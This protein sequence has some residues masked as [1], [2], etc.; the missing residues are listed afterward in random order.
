MLTCSTVDF[1]IENGVN[2]LVEVSLYIHTTQYI[3]PGFVIAAVRYK[4]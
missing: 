1:Y 2:I 4:D 3:L